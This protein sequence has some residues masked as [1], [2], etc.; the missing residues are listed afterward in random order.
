MSEFVLNDWS[1]QLK[2]A[3]AANWKEPI[4]RLLRPALNLYGRSKLQQ[5]TLAR[6]RPNLVL[7]GRGMPLCARQRWGY[8]YG[9]LRDKIILVQGTGNGWDAAS[10]AQYRPRKIVAVDLF[11]FPSWPQISEYAMARYSVPIEFYQAPLH[12]LDFLEDC[13]VDLC[14]SDAVYEHV[15]N[16]P[17]VMKETHRALKPNGYVYA[18]YG[19]LWYCAGGDHFA[20]GGLANVYNHVLLDAD[21]YM[22]F[23]EHNRREQE[24]FQSGGRYVELNLFSKLRTED[25]L[26]IFQEGG[27][28]VDSLVFEL[29]ATALK[30]RREQADLFARLLARHPACTPDDFVI[31]AHLIRLYK[32][33]IA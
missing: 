10:W 9:Q 4:Y 20:R 7:P 23:F 30:F 33:E 15:K 29:S 17:E 21:E 12:D 1:R 32:R 19:P 26:H 31:N 13:S 25:Y 28:H 16:L 18:S 27:F 2:G 3:E 14:A 8:A 24:S 6:F 11:D 5:S 22:G